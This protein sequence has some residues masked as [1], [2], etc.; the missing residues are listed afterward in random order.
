MPF[1]VFI[2]TIL[3]LDVAIL[4]SAAERSSARRY[5]GVERGARSA[6]E[7]EGLDTERAR[8]TTAGAD[9]RHGG[10]LEG[11]VVGG[12]LVQT[13]SDKHLSFLPDGV[14]YRIEVC[15]PLSFE[16]VEGH[17]IVAQRRRRPSRD[18]SELSLSV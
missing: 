3:F 14:V 15:H 12:H 8:R 9:H 16:I 11:F 18:V 6:G 1:R 10:L 7:E 17:A 5:P 4:L 13:W 2:R